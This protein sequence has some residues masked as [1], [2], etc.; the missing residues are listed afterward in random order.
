MRQD[1]MNKNQVKKTSNK[2]DNPMLALTDTTLNII[3]I[4][5]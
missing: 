5:E 4:S 2:G 1:L 3:T